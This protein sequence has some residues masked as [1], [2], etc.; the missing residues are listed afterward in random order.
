MFFHRNT[1]GINNNISFFYKPSLF[2][3]LCEVG[4]D[5]IHTFFFRIVKCTH[6]PAEA[7]LVD[8][9]FFL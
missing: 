8:Q 2:Q 5:I 3:N 1:A 4:Y 6:A 9:R 7:E